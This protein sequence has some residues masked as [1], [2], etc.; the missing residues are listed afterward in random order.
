MGR[1]ASNRI[2]PKTH[3]IE[4]SN[5]SYASHVPTG[6]RKV[7]SH[8][9]L[10]ILII[11][12]WMLQKFC[13][14]SPDYAGNLRNLSDP[15]N[16]RLSERIIQFPFAQPIVDDK[17]EEELSR[18][19]ERRKEQGRKLQE[20]AAKARQEKVCALLTIFKSCSNQV[21][22]DQKENDLQ[23]MLTLKDRRESE[24]KREWAVSRAL[25]TLC[26]IPLTIYRKR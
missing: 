1:I 19:A 21:K 6:K 25:N 14:F 10:T 15:L 13:E 2:S 4:I 7:T 8:S 26:E 22:L 17:T 9:Y 11:P 18:I 23:Y 16:L 24:S 12:Q 3:S 20:I 5:I